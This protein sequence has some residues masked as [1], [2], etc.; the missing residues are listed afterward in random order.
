MLPALPTGMQCTS[1]ASPS[2]STIS[3]APVFWPSMRNGF[4]EFTTTTG[5]RPGS[6]R[7]IS[8]AASKLPRTCRTRA[9]CTSACASLPRAMCP[10]GMSTAQRMPARAA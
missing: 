2:S 5:A 6:S 1:G 7:T 8:S 9:P 4:T 10:S 3:K